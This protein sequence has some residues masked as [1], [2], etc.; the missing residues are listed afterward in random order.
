MWA[1]GMG[2]VRGFGAMFGQQAIH[3]GDGMHDAGAATRWRRSRLSTTIPGTKLTDNYR[4][5]EDAKSPETRAFIDERMPTRRG[6]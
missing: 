6:I 1:V 3:T 5:L 4:W 2:F